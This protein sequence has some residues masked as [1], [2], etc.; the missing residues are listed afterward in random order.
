MKIFTPVY[1][2]TSKNKFKKKFR[3]LG[4]KKKADFFVSLPDNLTGLLKYIPF[5]AGL[6]KKGTV[7][8]LSPQTLADILELIKP[9]LFE[10]IYYQ[11]PIRLFTEPFKQL[12]KRFINQNFH[13]LIDLNNPANLHLPYLINS[14]RRITFY[15]KPYFPYY[16]ILIK[17]GIESLRQFLKIPGA[18]PDRIFK[19]QKRETKKILKELKKKSPLLVIN[20]GQEIEWEGDR[21]LI[22][23]E[24]PEQ[25]TLRFQ[26]LS[27]ADAYYGKKDELH[28]FARLLKKKIL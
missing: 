13:Y 27:V 24:I 3:P 14:E 18:K 6:K 1:L 5:I 11:K 26:I 8:L 7:K 22:G 9:K 25:G 23:R 28:Q 4:S 15:D 21:I 10:I 17:D 2:K 20:D 19:F 12:K 16:N